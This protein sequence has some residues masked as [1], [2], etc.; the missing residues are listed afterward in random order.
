MSRDSVDLEKFG[1]ILVTVPSEEE[2]TAIALN[3]LQEKLAACIK[4]VPVQSFYIWEGEI[5]RDSEWQLLIKT[6]L[7]HFSGIENKI[8]L[9]H[10]YEVPEIIAIPIVEGSQSYLS[11]IESSLIK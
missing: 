9:L 8:K 3:L 2:G 4:I 7:S 5:N 1:I 10:S 11:W 6:N